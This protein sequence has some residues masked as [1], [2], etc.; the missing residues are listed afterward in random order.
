MN[1][2]HTSITK[3][4]TSVATLSALKSI[5]SA[6]FVATLLL[7]LFSTSVFAQDSQPSDSQN[8]NSQWTGVCVQEISGTEVA[9]IQGIQCLIA[10]I[11]KIAVSF[12]GLVAFMIFIFSGFRILLSGGD[13][14][15]VESAKGS[16]TF[17]VVGLVVALSAFII[18]NL[19]SQ[20]TGVD[21]TNFVIPGTE[22]KIF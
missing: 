2:L 10:N 11:L 1:Q 6:L 9:T 19:I 17:A 4:S 21:L 3:L 13:S 16:I 22:F 5:S 12:I 20:F 18:L 7:F 14:K 8:F 15:A